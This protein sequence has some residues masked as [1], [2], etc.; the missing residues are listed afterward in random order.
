M[1]VNKEWERDG[2][3]KGGDEDVY[4]YL[5]VFGGI[6]ESLFSPLSLQVQ[7]VLTLEWSLDLKKAVLLAL[8]NLQSQDARYRSQR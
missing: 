8:R 4:L 1:E 3:W 7:F 6:V 5:V 2:R